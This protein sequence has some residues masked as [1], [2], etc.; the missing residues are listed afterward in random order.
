MAKQ[1]K[2]GPAVL[3]DRKNQRDPNLQTGRV[4][5]D[6][7]SATTG[8]LGFAWTA[9]RGRVYLTPVEVTAGKLPSSATTARAVGKAVKLI[10][11]STAFANSGD[12][13]ALLSPAEDRWLERYNPIAKRYLERGTDFQRERSV[14]VQN[15]LAEGL[16]KKGICECSSSR[17]PNPDSQRWNPQKPC[18]WYVGERG[19][20]ELE[21]LPGPESDQKAAAKRRKNQ[22]RNDKLELLTRRIQQQAE[23]D[24]QRVKRQANAPQRRREA[25]ETAEASKGKRCKILAK[26]Y[27]YRIKQCGN[28]Y[29]E[30]L[31]AYDK[32]KGSIELYENDEGSYGVALS[33]TTEDTRGQK[34]G[35]A[36][37]EAAVEALCKRGDTL[38]SG[39]T[40]SRFSEHW[41]RK[42]EEKGR[43]SCTAGQGEGQSMEEAIEDVEQDPVAMHEAQ[44]EYI[45]QNVTDSDLQ[46]AYYEDNPG[47]YD[48]ALQYYIEKRVDDN[49]LWTSYFNEN[50][51]DLSQA[52]VDY[53]EE[54]DLATSAQGAQYYS[55]PW[56]TTV[57]TFTR[58]IDAAKTDR[59]RENLRQELDRLNDYL[60]SQPGAE[61]RYEWPCQ[62]Y[63]LDNTVCKGKVIDLGKLPK[64]AKCP[65]GYRKHRTKSGQLTCRKVRKRQKGK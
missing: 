12:S 42:Q 45:Q 40:R 43:A 16:H 52:I 46:S 50:P 60:P 23:R 1:L 15:A 56:S 29:F 18:D 64:G 28:D 53:I 17:S 38:A 10:R 32:K 22:E 58:R 55:G 27:G 44:Q 8:S 34:V 7:P 21:L 59:E 25:L 47:E 49:E 3:M 39:T 65:P 9:R 19:I 33:T 13:V 63:T 24:K 5:V 62:R 51:D 41:W 48:E 4:Y 36:L 61:S 54:N 11:E 20:P 6:I 26:R 57:E 30:A 14:R 31:D 35:T 37:Y 2:L